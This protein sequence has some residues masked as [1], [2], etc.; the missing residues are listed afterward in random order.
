[1]KKKTKNEYKFDYEYFDFFEK[2]VNPILKELK[3]AILRDQ[4]EDVVTSV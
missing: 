2:N 4:P 3:H 1:M